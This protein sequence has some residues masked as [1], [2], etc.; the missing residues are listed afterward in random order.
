MHGRLAP[1]FAFRGASIF[2]TVRSS[3]RTRPS[4]LGGNKMRR[5]VVT[6]SGIVSPLGCGTGLVW[7]RLLDGRSGIRRLSDKIVHDVPAKLAGVVPLNA[8][9]A[10][11]GF[12]L[13][14]VVSHKD[15]KRMDRFIQFAMSAAVVV[16]VFVVWVFVFVWVCV[17]L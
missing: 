9:D 6:G 3:V 17:C 7:Q 5:I 4:A 15:H 1:R 14:H 8:E 16:F 12:D 11:G 2:D 10:E 13:D